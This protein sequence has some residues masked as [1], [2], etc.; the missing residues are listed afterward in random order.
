MPIPAAKKALVLTHEIT[1]E[2]SDTQN[3]TGSGSGKTGQDTDQPHPPLANKK[4]KPRFVDM[5]TRTRSIRVEEGPATAKYPKPSRRPSHGL[6]KL[7]ELAKQE[8]QTQGEQPLKTAP[9]QTD[10]AFKEAMGSTARNRSADRPSTSTNDDNIVAIKKERSYAPASQSSSTKDT[11]SGS[12]FNN[13]KQ[14]STGLGKA[15]M[16][17]GK[18]IFG[19]ITRSGSSNERELLTDEGYTCTVINLPLIEQTRKTRIAKGL[20]RSKDKTE[21]WMPALPWRCIE[22]VL[23]MCLR[24]QISC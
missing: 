15:G 10:R 19:K 11:S 14:Q 16:K 9:L 23:Y 1:G 22:Y 17:A 21:F 5:L 4:S 12:L 6:L 18:G 20:D 13:L 24:C 7:E 3:N 8:S 2:G